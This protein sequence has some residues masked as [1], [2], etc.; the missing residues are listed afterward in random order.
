MEGLRP[1]PKGTGW[2][3]RTSLYIY[4][5]VTRINQGAP[6]PANEIAKPVAT[7][8][9]GRFLFKNRIA[10]TSHINFK[11]DKSSDAG[12]LGPLV[13]SYI[14]GAREGLRPGPKGAGG[15]QGIARTSLFNY[16]RFKESHFCQGG[17]G[18]AAPPP[19][20]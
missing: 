13:E 1:G 16:L 6:T 7:A 3:A 12:R 9:P 15:K 2:N 14:S 5:S 8:K 18:P 19:S 10:R 17:G 4:V 11:T 20:L